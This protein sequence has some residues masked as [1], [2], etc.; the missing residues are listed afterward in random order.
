MIDILLDVESRFPVNRDLLRGRAHAVLSDHGVKTAAEVAISIVGD[1]K[2]KHLNSKYRRIFE[3]TDV[4]SFPLLENESMP[5]ASPPDGVLR[6][7]DVVISYPQAIT[8]AAS[9]NKM[10]DEKLCELLE[11]GL[12]H[13][14]GIHHE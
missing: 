10:V 4:L 8:E 9:E 13:L 6:L 12:L 2:M 11:H 3:T 7:G 1:R 14:L 5:F